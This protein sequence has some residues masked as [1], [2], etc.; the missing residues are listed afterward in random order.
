MADR[1]LYY[2]Y[3]HIRDVEWLKSTLLLFSEVRRMT[4]LPGV[5]P[6]DGPIEPYTQWQGGKEP[7][8]RS[9]DLW[10]ARAIAAQQQLA[11]RLRRDAQDDNFRNLYGRWGAAPGDADVH[12]FQI[13]QQK[14]D[15]SLQDALR[16]TELAWAPG[17]PEP[18]DLWVD[19][20]EMHPRVGQAVMATLAIA[21]ATGEG[22]DVVGDARSGQ[23]HTCL[24]QKQAA[25]AYDAWL[26]PHADPLK[27]SAT[28]LFGYVVS[29]A[30][31]TTK[32]DA[33]ALSKMGANREPVRRLMKALTERAQSMSA[34]DPGKYRDQQFNDEAAAILKAW[35]ED[36]ANMDNYWRQFFGFGL[37]D[38]ATKPL[39]KFIS[40]VAESIP[41]GSVAATGALAGLSLGGPLLAAGSGIGF[42]LFAHAAKTYVDLAK[43]AKDSPYQYL[44]AMEDAGVIFRIDIPTPRTAQ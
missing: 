8:V 14:L 21:C 9:A 15:P 29:F 22:L 12:G 35:R 26:K 18:Y 4:P 23:L 13:H 7:M 38:A 2:P 41:A 5:Q 40:K 24:V 30:C 36:R 34:M 10:S 37:V 11:E 19:Y 6:D 42:G 25:L 31:D 20:V 1:A 16:E 28:E 43:R 27:P 17:N 39:E 32:L 3:I 44:T 33:E